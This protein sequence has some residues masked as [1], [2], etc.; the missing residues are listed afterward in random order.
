MNEI[1]SIQNT[2]EY[3]TYEHVFISKMEASLEI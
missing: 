3:N 1:R 2:S